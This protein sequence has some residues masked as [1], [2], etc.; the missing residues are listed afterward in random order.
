MFL[1]PVTASLSGELDVLPKLDF[2]EPLR[3]RNPNPNRKPNR[4]PNLNL[5]P[6]S[7]PNPDP[8]SGFPGSVPNLDCLHLDLQLNSASPPFL[9]CPAPGRTLSLVKMWAVWFVCHYLWSIEVYRQ[10]VQQYRTIKLD[11]TIHTYIHTY[12][13]AYIHIYIHLYVL[14][15]KVSKL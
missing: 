10:C 2:L 13:H 4:K 15:G 3:G 5:N 9:P 12:I 1:E 7:N 14:Y 8:D 6:N 11:G